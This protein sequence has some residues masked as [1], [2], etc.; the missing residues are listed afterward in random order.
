LKDSPNPDDI[1]RGVDIDAYIR[2]L[3]SKLLE[4]AK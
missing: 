2:G 1:W 3:A 4:V